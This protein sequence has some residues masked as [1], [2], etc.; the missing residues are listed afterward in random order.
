MMVMHSDNCFRAALGK[1][2][3][4][5]ATLAKMFFIKFVGKDFFF[6]P[7]VWAFADKGREFFKSLKTGAMLGCRCHFIFPP[8]G[9]V[10]KGCK[11]RGH[12]KG[13]I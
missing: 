2:H 11:N 4:S 8:F 3:F 12:P 13:C 7:T 9:Y 5:I 10:S 6:F 1:I